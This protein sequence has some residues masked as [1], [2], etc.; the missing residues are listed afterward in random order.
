MARLDYAGSGLPAGPDD[1]IVERI[2]ARRGGTLTSLDRMLLHS[3]PLADGWNSLMGAVRTASTLPADVRELAILR[4]AA[5]NG[6]DY[7]WRA[8]E[9]LG[10]AAGLTDADLTALRGDCDPGTLAPRL[11]AALAY[12]DAMTAHV[13]VPDEVFAYLREH[14]DDREVVEL[15][16]TI[17]AYNLVSRFLVALH[18]GDEGERGAA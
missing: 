9:P 2:R 13:T 6:A 7:E 16:V 4:V 10:R 5:L 8:H 3:P 1:E 18:V 12:T 17:G 11:S 15:T 14:F